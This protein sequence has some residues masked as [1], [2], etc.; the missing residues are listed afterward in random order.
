MDRRSQLELE[1]CSWGDETIDGGELCLKYRIAESGRVYNRQCK[2]RRRCFDDRMNIRFHTA[3]LHAGLQGPNFEFATRDHFLRPRIPFPQSQQILF[4]PFSTGYLATNT[5]DLYTI[6]AGV[7]RRLFSG[8]CLQGPNFEL[9]RLGKRCQG[10]HIKRYQLP[11]YG[12]SFSES[13]IS[14]AETS[15]FSGTWLRRSWL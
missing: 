7:A 6:I 2:F 4:L 11:V 12:H 5:H 9:R 14:R 13:W 3:G 10:D 8:T 1:R 15:P